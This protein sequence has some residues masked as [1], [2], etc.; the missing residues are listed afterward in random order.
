MMGDNGGTGDPS[1]IGAGAGAPSIGAT[2][3]DPA[4]SDAEANG[5]AAAATGRDCF[6]LEPITGLSLAVNP[7][8]LSTDDI[9]LCCTY[10]VTSYYFLN[11]SF[12]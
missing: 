10:M 9:I 3:L 5:E 8:P 4:A 7:L 6:L 1:S 12:Y 2:G 11:N